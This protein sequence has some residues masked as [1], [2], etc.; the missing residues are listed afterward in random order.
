MGYYT[1]FNLTVHTDRFDE[2]EIIKDFR[3]NSDYAEHCLTETGG[4]NEEGKWYDHEEDLRKLSKKYPNVLFE[5][6][7]EGEESGDLW[8]LYAKNQKLQKERAKITYGKC[9]LK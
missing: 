2:Q 9:K 4:T 5:M 6:H 7:G 8:V 1:R 3:E